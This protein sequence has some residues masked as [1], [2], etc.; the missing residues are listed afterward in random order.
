MALLYS[1]LQ[2]STCTDTVGARYQRAQ[3]TFDVSSTHVGKQFADNANTFAESANG[4]TGLIPGWRIYNVQA[5]WRSVPQGK[6]GPEIRLGINNVTDKRYY[7][8]N[9]DANIGKMAAAPRMIYLQGR[10][11]F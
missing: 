7:T 9:V 8:R 11:A 10:C 4:G 2:G 6:K 3:W 1:G 5:I